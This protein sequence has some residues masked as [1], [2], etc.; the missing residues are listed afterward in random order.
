MFQFE[1][2]GLQREGY[3]VQPVHK[4]SKMN[5]G[6][7]GCGKTQFRLPK[8]SGHDFSR[9]ANATKSPRALAPE[10][11]FFQTDP[12]SSHLPSGFFLSA[13]VYFAQFDENRLNLTM[14]MPAVICSILA[15]FIGRNWAEFHSF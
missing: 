8:V 13:R 12:L 14:E 3:G 10:G 9:A 6:F 4:S 15:R 5:R 2:Y 1:G 7:I 11:G